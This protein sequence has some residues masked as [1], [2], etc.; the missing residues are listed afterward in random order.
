MSPRGRCGCGSAVAAPR[1]VRPMVRGR[2]TM[3]LDTYQLAAYLD[4]ALDAA[5]RAAT[6]AH[7]LTCPACA[8]RLDRLRDDARR[9]TSVSAS[10]PTPDVRAAVRVRL[11]RASPFTWLARGGAFAGALAALLLFAV[12][13]G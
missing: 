5:T 13:I 1:S 3:H 7:I 4:G 12:L 11:R 2:T 8:A 9:I 10:S 6:R